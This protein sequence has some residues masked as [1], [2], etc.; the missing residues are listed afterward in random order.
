MSDRLTPDDAVWPS[1][2]VDSW[3]DT[4]ET[5]HMMTQIVGKIQLGSTTL[6]NQWWNVA[7]EVSARGLRTNTMHSAGRA[8]DAE[9]DFIAS[10]LVF[11]TSDGGLQK[12]E[13]KP[14]SIA[15]FYGAVQ[16]ALGQIEVYVDIQAAPNEVE[17]PIPFAQDT[18]HK[19]YD[20]DAV[21]IFWKQL[22]NANR[23]LEYWRAGF[24]GKSSD[25]QLWWGGLDLA[26]TRFSGR[27]APLHPKGAPHCP[28]WVNIE[29]YD[30]E[31][32]SGGFWPGGS[33]EGVFYAYAYPE[34]K[35]YSDQAAGAGHWDK[36]LG[37]FVLPYE[38]VATSPDPD[39]TV[40]DFL[41]ATYLSAAKLADWDTKL[42][43]LNPRRLSKQITSADRTRI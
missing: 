38:K 15:D 3:T 28:D 30:R 2:L 25:P 41:E 14:R 8:F 7:F 20:A 1:L 43:D 6:V 29:A 10:E 36:D 33:G 24:G 37:E 35:G 17:N 16:D 12:V 21:N 23:V 40:L 9:F 34:P 19:A 4:R 32:M 42:L 18:T 39:R 26:T 22:I 11:R 13:L 31:C 5:L 27:P